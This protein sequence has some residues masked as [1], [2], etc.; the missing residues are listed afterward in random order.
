MYIKHG[1]EYSNEICT[2]EIDHTDGCGMMLPCVS[3]SNFMVRAPYV[4]GLL[5]TFDF[6]GFCR[7]KNVPAVIRDIY[8]KE[9]DLIAENIQIL[10]TESQFKMW[11]HYKDWD[12]YKRYFKSC[13]AQFC[14]TNYEEE[15]I[16]DVTTN[17]QFTQTLTDFTDEEIAQYTHN[18][19]QKILNITKNKDTMLE[20]LKAKKESKNSFRAAL[21]YYEELLWDEYIRKQ[22]KDIRHKMIYDAMSGKIRMRNKRLYAIPDFY[23]ACEFWFQHIEHPKG[24]LKKGE[25]ACRVYQKYDKADVLRSPHLYQEHC[26]RN[27]SHDPEVYRWFTTNGVHTAVDDLISRVLQFD[28]DGDQLNVVVEPLFVEVAERNVQKFDIIPLFYDADKADPEELNNMTIFNGLK[29]A[30]E[31]SNSKDLSI[32]KI[33]NM[34]TR[35]WNKDKPDR[36]VA[37]WLTRF[38]NL[39]IDAAKTGRI[40]HYNQY[41]LIE[42]KINKAIGGSKGRMP[43]WFQFSVNS[44]NKTDRKYLEPNKSTMNRICAVFEPL[45]KKNIN[46]KAAN[47]PPFNW[48]M[49]LSEDCTEDNQ[50]MYNTFTNVAKVNVSNIVETRDGEYAKD[51]DIQAGYDLLA[52]RTAEAMTEVY[53]PLENSFPYITKRL[54]E[55]KGIERTSFKQMYWR[56]Y[57]QI[58]LENIIKNMETHKTC[59]KC[60][61]K[62]PAW[63]THECP[64]EIKGYK[65]CERCGKMFYLTNS[66]QKRCTDCQEEIRREK[67]AERQKVVY[68]KK[69]EKKSKRT[70]SLVSRLRKM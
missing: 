64:P 31:F 24:L 18:E 65:R 63:E 37:A 58:A 13:G 54:Y 56:V 11:K 43:Y 9:H 14:K 25:I 52:A 36:L 67:E 69:K 62:Y 42:R 34:L 22:L 60:G 49:L 46:L 3:E 5:S 48:K 68:M 28:V 57:G 2:V 6:I 20:T 38:N 8:G 1:Y 15:E 39:V 21:A 53:G 40:D 47:V 7:E 66:Q 26:V 30:H 55:G 33:S 41:P 10:F 27:I 19:Y 51:R 32:G 29:R 17:Y 16:L 4:K 35:L 45:K 12:E 23:A 70:G 44:R 61:M 59:P 50:E